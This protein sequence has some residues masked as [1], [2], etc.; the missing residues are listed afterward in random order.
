MTDP[1]GRRFAGQ[2]RMVRTVLRQR[3]KKQ[4]TTV[5]I[6]RKRSVGTAPP[7]GQV[8]YA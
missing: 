3:E 7:P 1:A 2:L 6:R 4:F 8:R 5:A